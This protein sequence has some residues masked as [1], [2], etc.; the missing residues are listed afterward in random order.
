[1]TG[2]QHRRTNLRRKLRPAGEPTYDSVTDVRI[3]RRDGWQCQMPACLHPDGRAIT[4]GLPVTDVW[5]ASIDHI[6]PLA[7]GGRDDA[8]N[9]RAAHQLCNEAHVAGFGRRVRHRRALTY[10]I[11]D[12]AGDLLRNLAGALEQ[13]SG[14]SR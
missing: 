8:P 7:G 10:T 14:G 2:S 3:Y 5:R 12:I 6:E 11:G 9:K 13:K 1:M 4:P